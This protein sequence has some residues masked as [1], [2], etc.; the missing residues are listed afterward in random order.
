MSKRRILITGGTGFFGKSLLH[1]FKQHGADN[2]EIVILS[3]NPARF[4]GQNPDFANIPGVEFIAGDVRNFPFPEETFDAVIHAASPTGAELERNDPVELRSIIVDGTRHILD[5][6]QD[7]QVKKL[8]FISSGAVY[9]VQRPDCERM[10]ENSPCNPVT[11]YGKAKLE[12]EELCSSSQVPT[13]I[14]RCF[15]FIGPYLPLDG[16]FAAGNF[17]ADALK[18]R[19]ITIQGD[20]RPLRSY[21]YADDLVRYLWTLLESD[22]VG[23]VYNIGGERAVSISELAQLCSKLV[24]PPL[25]VK[26]FGKSDN[27]PAPRYVPDVE[28][29]KRELGLTPAVDL[30]IAL[31]KTINFHLKDLEK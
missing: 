1:D 14:A 3:R 29:I 31:Q 4:T 10:A 9:G 28:K 26:I 7:R 6:C 23:E 18:A 22:K 12:S 24:S 13:V 8:L 16:H 25:P 19:A 2:T 27:S 5:F 11:A 15:A 17:I 21:L 20:G 30:E